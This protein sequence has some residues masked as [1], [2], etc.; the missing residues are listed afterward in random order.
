MKIAAAV[1]LWIS[2]LRLDWVRHQCKQVILIDVFMPLQAAGV[3]LSIFLKSLL[4]W[5]TG[6]RHLCM[7]SYGLQSSRCHGVTTQQ[8]TTTVASP[9]AA[10]HAQHTATPAAPA[11]S[12]PPPAHNSKAAARLLPAAVA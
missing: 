1:V 6:S 10:G 4:L 9:A 3:S 11:M 12:S 5:I 2:R 7:L 8:S